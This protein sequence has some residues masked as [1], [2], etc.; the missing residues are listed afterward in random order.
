MKR[1]TEISHIERTSNIACLE[2]D[3]LRP[4]IRETTVYDHQEKCVVKKQYQLCACQTGRKQY[5]DMLNT[6]VKEVNNG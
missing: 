2:C 4:L 3:A 6:Q 1:Y 5:Y